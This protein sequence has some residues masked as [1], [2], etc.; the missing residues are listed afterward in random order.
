MRFI[1][2]NL[3]M[4][5]NVLSK[6]DVLSDKVH[7]LTEWSLKKPVIR[8]NTERFNHYVKT[9]PR[10][11]SMIVMLTAMSPQRQCGICKQAHDEFQVVAQSYRY[12]NAFSNKVFFGMVDF[13]DGAEIFQSLKLNTAPVFIHFPQ[14]GKPK[15]GDQMDLSR[16]GFSAEQMVKWVH[17]CADVSIQIVRPA[18]YSRMLLIGLIAVMFSVLLYVKR[19][20]FEFLYN[21]IFWGIFVLGFVCYF[22]SGQTWNFINGPPFMPSQRD[23]MHIF[24]DDSNMQFVAE[25]Y[26]VFLLYF[27]VSIGMILLNEAPK[28]KSKG[29]KRKAMVAILGILMVV[30]LF[31]FILSIFRSKYQGYPYSFLIK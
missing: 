5:L 13:D 3:C 14:K 23:G 10:N 21:Y 1:F 26:I 20:S 22:I 4:I 19:N 15:K 12:S 25:T 18:N 31:S 30:F 2:L 24:A 7:Q 9:S 8:L 29:G 17:D 6:E 28:L 27:G 11:Y 16:W